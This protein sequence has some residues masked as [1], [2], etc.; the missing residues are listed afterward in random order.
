MFLSGFSTKNNQ[1]IISGRGIGL[2]I[3]KSEIEK[4]NGTISVYSEKN[5]GTIFKI[6]IPT[7]NNN[8]L[9]AVKQEV[10]NE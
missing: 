10:N 5:E 7:R 8:V 4:L 3:V 9:K 2:D 6:I 1:D